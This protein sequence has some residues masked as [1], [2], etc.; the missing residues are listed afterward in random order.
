MSARALLFTAIGVAAAFSAHASDEPEEVPARPVYPNP[1]DYP[2]ACEP[3][4]AESDAPASVT[5]VYEVR[6]DGQPRNVRVRESSD[7]CFNDAAVAAVR[8]WDF[9]PRRVNGRRMVQ[10]DLETTFI[11]VM[12]EE[13]RAVNFD[14]RPI[15]R[16]PPLYPERCMRGAEDMETVHMRFDVTGQ[17]ATE[18]IEVIESS[19]RC[20]NSPAINAVERWIYRPKLIDGAPARRD[21]VETLITFYLSDGTHSSWRVRDSVRRRLDRAR[22]DAVRR[23]DYDK[24]ME[25]LR[26]VEEEYGANFSQAETAEYYYVRAVIRIEMKDY[27]GALDD[28]R[29]VQ[30]TGIASGEVS[31]AINKMVASIELFLAQQGA[32]PEAEEE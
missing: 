29:I 24:A 32:D 14:A 26:N 18:N 7:S 1:P 19:S 6:R 23:K 20:L 21:G 25:R 5:V 30:D 13:T 16:V 28:L 8:S 3:A 17:G 10:E 9:E 4:A 11:F 22:R 31:E 27:R 15:T 12:E 2:A